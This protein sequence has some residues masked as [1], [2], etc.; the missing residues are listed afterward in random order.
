MLNRIQNGN[1]DGLLRRTQVH[2]AMHRSGAQIVP[3]AAPALKSGS[4]PSWH[5]ALSGTAEWSTSREGAHEH[6]KS[7]RVPI[8]RG[9]LR[10]DFRMHL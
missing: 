10:G 4:L 3:L 2:A 8:T 5:R 7:N 1:I 6:H 9:N